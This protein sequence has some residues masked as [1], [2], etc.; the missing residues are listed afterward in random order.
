MRKGQVFSLGFT[1]SQT[2]SLTG[3]GGLSENDHCLG[4]S[5]HEFLISV[6]NQQGEIGFGQQRGAMNSNSLLNSWIQRIGCRSPLVWMR[7][8][9]L[10]RSNAEAVLCFQKAIEINPNRLMH[11]IELESKKQALWFVSITLSQSSRV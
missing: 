9:V 1:S 3:N 8:S 6:N 2:S 7:S 4:S 10:L 5:A 11:Y